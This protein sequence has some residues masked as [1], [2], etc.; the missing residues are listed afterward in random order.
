MNRMTLTGDK[1]YFLFNFLYVNITNCHLSGFYR[2][3]DVVEWEKLNFNL[4]LTFKLLNVIFTTTGHVRTKH[5]AKS[6]YQNGTQR[7]ANERKVACKICSSFKNQ[8]NWNRKHSWLATYTEISLLHTVACTR[9]LNRVSAPLST[10]IKLGKFSPS[11]DSTESGQQQI[12]LGA[13]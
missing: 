4:T 7:E 6:A 10:R 5:S 13:P 11:L 2:N 9:F 3:C 12:Q 1:L 8:L